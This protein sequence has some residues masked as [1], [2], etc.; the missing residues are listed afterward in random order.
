[1]T[2]SW[3]TSCPFVLSLAAFHGLVIG[4]EA[5]TMEERCRDSYLRSEKFVG[6]YKSF[7]CFAIQLDTAATI[8][9]PLTNKAV[10]IEFNEKDHENGIPDAIFADVSG[11]SSAGFRY[12]FDDDNRYR[13]GLTV[14]E[15][16]QDRFYDID[17]NFGVCQYGGSCLIAL[18]TIQIES[19]CSC[20]QDDLLSTMTNDSNSTVAPCMVVEPAPSVAPTSSPSNAPTSSMVPTSSMAASFFTWSFSQCFFSSSCR[21]GIHCHPALGIGS[22]YGLN[23]PLKNPCSCTLF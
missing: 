1:M 7:A 16:D 14:A 11:A 3:I 15:L 12:P 13:K 20:T 8:N 23:V 2:F 10:A 6:W 21:D 9:C 22:G 17:I 4:V 19:S 18:A 5:K